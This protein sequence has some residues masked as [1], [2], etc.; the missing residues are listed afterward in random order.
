MSE[1]RRWSAAGSPADVSGGTHPLTAAIA[2]LLSESR[3]TKSG[4]K[5]LARFRRELPVGHPP[6]YRSF[7]A[8]AAIPER[9]HGD[10][11]WRLTLWQSAVADLISV[12]A[13]MLVA[14]R[15]PA[16][17]ANRSRSSRLGIWHAGAASDEELAPAHLVMERKLLAKSE[18]ATASA[19]CCYAISKRCSARVT[20][21]GRGTLGQGRRVLCADRADH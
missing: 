12:E 7:T 16:P 19:N 9:S 8:A 13:T 20:R 11:G 5:P 15:L 6:S 17:A 10:D 3:R 14:G 21:R 18:S 2:R 4:R 1:R